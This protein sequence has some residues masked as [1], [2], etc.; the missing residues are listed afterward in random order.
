VCNVLVGWQALYD[1]STPPPSTSPAHEADVMSQNASTSG[2][3]TVAEL[4]HPS[5]SRQQFDEN[6]SSVRYISLL[7]SALNFLILLIRVLLLVLDVL[8]F[9]IKVIESFHGLLVSIKYIWWHT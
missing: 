5:T 9:S 1:V 4:Q 3:E 2:P 8:S 6:I 7:I